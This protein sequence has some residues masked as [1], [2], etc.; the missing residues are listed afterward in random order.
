MMRR[1][2]KFNVGDKVY[3]GRHSSSGLVGFGEIVGIRGRFN[4]KYVVVTEKGIYYSV[5][6]GIIFS[7]K[8]L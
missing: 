8:R 3:V 6:Q 2:P 1:K 4:I 7:T 5:P